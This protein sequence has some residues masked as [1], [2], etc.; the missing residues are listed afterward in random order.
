MVSMIAQSVPSAWMP[1][2][3]STA[4]AS[5]ACDSFHH[6]PVN[7]PI[8][9]ELLASLFWQ[10]GDLPNACAP[11][12]ATMSARTAHMVLVQ[13]PPITLTVPPSPETVICICLVQLMYTTAAVQPTSSLHLMVLPRYSAELKDRNSSFNGVP[14]SVWNL[15]K[16]HGTCL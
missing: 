9:I 14:G 13:W 6:A 7:T 4:S 5:A 8:L 1:H 11:G 3:C 15:E 12:R 10:L 16:L 2:A